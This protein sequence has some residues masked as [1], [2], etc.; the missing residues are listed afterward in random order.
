MSLVNK[1]SILVTG[2]SGFIGN[3]LC[4]EL[5]KL[6]YYVIRG[7]HKN[8]KNEY[9]KPNKVVILDLNEENLD[10]WRKSLLN[11]DCVIHCAGK[12]DEKNTVQKRELKLIN[13]NGTIN[14]INQCVNNDI[15]KFIFISSI[16]VNGEKS[17]PLKRNNR[18]IFYKIDENDIPNPKSEYGKSKF[19][20]ENGIIQISKKNKIDFTIIRSPIVYGPGLKGNIL[21]LIKLLDLNIPLPFKNIN[22]KR[23]LIYIKNLIDLIITCVESPNSKNQ[24]FLASDDHALSTTELLEN[25]KNELNLQ[26]RLFYFPKF[27]LEFS[28]K[29]IGKKFI[30]DRLFD[31]LFVSNLKSKKV[32]GW[33]PVA[34][35]REGLYETIKWYQKKK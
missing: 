19:D 29:I 3:A 13:T 34:D 7:I 9:F 1:K 26:S 16:K 21:K 32:L 28:F 5:E 35:I 10:K 15:K 24:I 11:I 27:L 6:N 33:K 17:L 25:I 30:F 2:A 14:L 20:A 18:D 23:S 8:R 12:S 22:N 4:E 31:S